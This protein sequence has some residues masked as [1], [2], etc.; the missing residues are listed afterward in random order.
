MP[1]LKSEC[2]LIISEALK[3]KL[4]PQ[5]S[6]KIIPEIRAAMNYLDRQN[7]EGWAAASHMERVRQAS[8]LAAANLQ[9]KA[10]Q[11]LRRAALQIEAVH[12]AIYGD[13]AAACKI[14]KGQKAVAIVLESAFKYVKGTRT[15]YAS[16]VIDGMKAI[17]ST[18]FGLKEDKKTAEL[19]VRALLGE[20]VDDA[21]ITAGAKIIR[22]TM[23]EMTDRANK[24]GADIGYLKNYLPQSHDR[25][26]VI[27]AKE[28]IDGA[29]IFTMKLK[30]L[31]SWSSASEDKAAWVNFIWDKLDRS[32]YTDPGTGDRLDDKA[33][34]EMLGRIYDTIS[35]NGNPG[36]EGSF[37]IPPKK[38]SKA[39]SMGK[40]RGIFFKDADSYL[41]YENIFGRGNITQRIIG[42]INTL[43]KDIA[44]LEKFGP[45][46]DATVDTLIAVAD[47]DKAR[48]IHA[49]NLKEEIANQWDYANMNGA[50]GVT[51]QEMWSVLSGRADMTPGGWRGTFASIMQG[52]RNLQVAGKLGG[53]FLSSFSDLGTYFLQARIN[54]VPMIEAAMNLTR[55]FGKESTEYASRIGIL[56]DEM[57]SGL[58]KWGDNNVGTGW[59]SAAANL[60][61]KLSLLDGWTN[62]VRRAAAL[63]MMAATAK[64]RQTAWDKLD[65]YDRRVLERSGITERIWRVWQAAEVENYRG[66]N[67]LTID[68]LDRISDG[69]LAGLGVTRTE[70]EG[71]K[72]AYLSFITDET[73]MASLDPDLATRAAA[74]RGV[75]KG[76]VTGE[77]FRSF[78]LFKSFPIGMITRHFQRMGDLWSTGRRADAV[79]YAAALTTGTTLFGAL[80]LQAANLVAGRDLQD[81]NDKR[82]WLNAWAKGGGWGVLGDLIYNGVSGE[83]RFGSPT[84]LSFMLGPVFG[85]ASDTYDYFASLAGSAAWDKDTKAAAKGLKV[86]RGNVP[87]LNV[88]WAK[89]ALDHAIFNDLN[90]WASPGYLRRQ[91]QRAMK[92]YG[93]GYWLSPNGL[94]MSRMPRV[95]TA[96]NAAPIF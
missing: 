81:P 28:F 34:T 61:M 44:L 55:A 18:W 70:L 17:G 87:F 11:R 66:S 62:G 7:P 37:I 1:R 20:K 65:G 93:Q 9:E 88:W 43:A 85:T 30:G 84:L 57:S 76:T 64:L 50:A 79:A 56:A 40:H 29:N 21:N 53:A 16:R 22:Q 6:E 14:A 73:H 91:R 47:G 46:C 94:S 77:F 41:A 33:Y 69:Q 80:S 51:T 35:T 82:F 59:T 4:T 2:E 5:E 31:K 27:H 75:A 10:R 90:E 63:N 25:Y 86:L 60:T 71:M 24:L 26:R 23:D 54:R 45:N 19:M 67:L 8:A 92:S 36:D 68:G 39:A 74:S 3:R 32:R 78:M 38:G 52:A 95:V 42:H 72:S 89:A 12:R 58:A 15:Y 83:N 49:E 13:Y 48:A 96:P